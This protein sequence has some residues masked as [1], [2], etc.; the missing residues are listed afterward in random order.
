[1]SVLPTLTPCKLILLKSGVSDT[2]YPQFFQR[3]DHGHNMYGLGYVLRR[4]LVIGVWGNN[5][6]FYLLT[7]LKYRITWI[8][9]WSLTINV[10]F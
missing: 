4:Y 5:W 9:V 6:D 7:S 10:G 3:F 2:T 8:L 1:M